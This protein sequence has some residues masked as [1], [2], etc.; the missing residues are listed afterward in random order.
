MHDIW[1]Q[2]ERG[3][4]RSDLRYLTTPPKKAPNSES[5]GR[6]APRVEAWTIVLR[7]SAVEATAD[8]RRPGGPR[9][10]GVAEVVRASR[11]ELGARFGER[12]PPTGRCSRTPRSAGRNP[13]GAGRPGL[14]RPSAG[15]CAL[16]C[17]A[18]PRGG[19]LGCYRPPPR[20]GQLGCCRPPPRGAA[21]VKTG[22]F[23]AYALSFLLECAK[24]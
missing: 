22:F 1:W 6:E 7:D 23:E 21:T 18:A 2:N 10:D 16:P 3:G 20:G 8:S 11:V 12:G 4:R 5:T 15:G 13:A 17:P 19:Q 9:R 14:R 24:Q